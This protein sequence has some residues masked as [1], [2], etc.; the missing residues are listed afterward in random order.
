MVFKEGVKLKATGRWR[1]N[2]QNSAVADKY[3]YVD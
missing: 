3:S 1:M 2:G